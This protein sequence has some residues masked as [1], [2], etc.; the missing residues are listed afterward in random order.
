MARAVSVGSWCPALSAACSAAEYRSNRR[1]WSRLAADGVA[2]D[3]I[4]D[5]TPVLVIRSE[6]P[7]ASG[8]WCPA[9]REMDHIVLHAEE[10]VAIAIRRGAGVEGI[11]RNIGTKLETRGCCA[12]RQSVP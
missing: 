9:R 10:R 8:W 4:G 6:R 7:E 11:C 12:L 2:V 5:Q 3:W 1:H